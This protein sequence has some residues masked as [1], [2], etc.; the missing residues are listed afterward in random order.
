MKIEV[1]DLRHVYPTG[2]EALRGVSLSMEGSQPVAIIGQNGSG[3]TTLVKHLNG[4]LRPTS[5]DVLVDGETIAS[6][7]T[8][9]WSAKVGYVFQNPDDQLFLDTVRG[10]L[11]FGPRKIGMSESAIAEKVAFAA[12]LCGLEDFLAKHPFDLSQTQK[13]FCTI[14]S[15]IAMDPGVL[16]FDEPT[17]GQDPRGVARLAAIVASLRDLGKL[18]IT[19]S[20]DMKFVAANFPRVVALCEGLVILD[21]PA[22]EVFSRPGELQRTFVSPPPVTRIAQR[23]GMA[24]TPFTVEEFMEGY[25][26]MR[27]GA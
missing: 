19:I 5:G 17:C 20:H 18:C 8:A 13:K 22:S 10:E 11:E 16:V 27:K 9:K 15:I 21:G 4:I 26:R 7:S 14:A 2:E 1:R 6:R 25:E 12:K 24:G 3:K 23:L